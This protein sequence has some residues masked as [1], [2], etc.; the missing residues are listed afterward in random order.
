MRLVVLGPNAQ[1]FSLRAF[2]QHMDPGARHAADQIP[3][4]SRRQFKP[5]L[6]DK[7]ELL[8]HVESTITLEIPEG[9][10]Q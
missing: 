6:L 5:M 2:G 4:M 7:Q 3:L 8:K 10:R 9:A 1:S